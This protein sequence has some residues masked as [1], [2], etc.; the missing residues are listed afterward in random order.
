L[1]AT[2]TIRCSLRTYPGYSPANCDDRWISPRRNATSGIGNQQSRASFRF[3]GDLQMTLTKP[4]KP[5]RNHI[6]PTD[7]KHWAKHWNVTPE[8]IEGAIEKV[9]NSVAAVEKFLAIQTAS[10]RPG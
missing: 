8:Q 4:V 9:G 6:Q 5:V 2:A 3:P 1:I 7:I 10:V